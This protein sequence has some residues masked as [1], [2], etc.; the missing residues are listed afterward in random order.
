MSLTT[1]NILITGGAGFIGSNLAKHL[2]QHN[3]VSVFDNFTTGSS[4]NKVENVTYYQDDIRNISKYLFPRTDVVFHLAAHSRIQ[5]S[6]KHPRETF[7][8]NTRGTIEMLDWSLKMKVEKFIYSGS[9]SKWH[10]PTISPYATS[11]YLGEE[12]VKMYRTA[13]GLNADITRFYNVYGQ[14]EILHGDWAAIVGRWRGQIANGEPVTIVGSGEQRRAFTHVTDIVDGL[15]RVAANEQ[16][17]PDAWELGANKNYS[18]N[19]I[20]EMFH[21]RFDADK[22]HIPERRGEYSE[23]V[24]ENTDALDLL[25]WNPTGSLEQYVAEL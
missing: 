5:P 20:Y 9:S 25:G 10:N 23:T 4:E 6:F 19:E 3:T 18:I 16:P 15:E 21:K 1:K 24:R 22:I 12:L 14:N 7:D 13:F 8:V 17:H 11:K 2:A